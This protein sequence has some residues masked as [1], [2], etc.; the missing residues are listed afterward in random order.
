MYVV[1]IIVTSD[2]DSNDIMIYDSK[3]NFLAIILGVLFHRKIVAIII[4]SQ[5]LLYVDLFADSGDNKCMVI[6]KQESKFTA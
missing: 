6:V 1:S 2:S 3:S 4:L 5:S